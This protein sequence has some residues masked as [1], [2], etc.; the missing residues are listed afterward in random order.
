MSLLEHID[1]PRDL[2]SLSEEELSELAQE[3]RNVGAE[4]IPALAAVILPACM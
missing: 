1:G 4:I 3:V 2:E